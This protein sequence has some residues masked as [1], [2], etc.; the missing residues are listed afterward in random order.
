ML[1]VN[2]FTTSY[3]RPYY[4]YNII[5]NVLN[6]SYKNI[7]Y[8]INI[9][10]D[11]DGEELLYKNLLLDFSQDSRLRIHFAYNESQHTNYCRAIS[12]CNNYDNSIYIKIDDDDIYHKNYISDMVSEYEKQNKDILS[13][14]SNITINNQ[15]IKLEKMESIG[16]WKGDEHKT[17]FG[18][19]P[20]YI[21]NKKARDIIMNLTDNDIRSVHFF[22][23]AAWRT[24]W[25]NHDLSSN[26][27]KNSKNFSYHIHG[28]NVSSAYLLDPQ[29]KNLLFIDDEYCIIAF[30]MHPHWSSYIFLNKR[31][32]RLFNINNNDHGKYKI[33]DNNQI[34][35]VWDN[36][37]KEIYSKKNNK[38]SIYFQSI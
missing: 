27:L 26:I 36:W 1:D 17:Q 23:D 10:I 19:P 16:L 13:C 15:N 8:S 35:I 11:D 37:N 20:T 18:M 32:N 34:E 9:N 21:F 5:N 33:L 7:I 2:C 38:N 25:R 12:Y 31:N 22:E 28:K 6:Q 24:A 29:D 4:L 30:F 14:I 3:H